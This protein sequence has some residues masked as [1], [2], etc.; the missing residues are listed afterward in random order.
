MKRMI[1]ESLLNQN[2]I[3]KYAKDFL[4]Y[5]E[6][7]YVK[8]MGLGELVRVNAT[9]IHE[10]TDLTFTAH[11]NA[12]IFIY[13]NLDWSI[14]DVIPEISDENPDYIFSVYSKYV[15]G[16]IEGNLKI[17]Q[18]GSTLYDDVSLLNK[19][20]LRLPSKVVSEQDFATGYMG[21]NID[22]IKLTSQDNSKH[23]IESNVEGV[24]KRYSVK[25]FFDYVN[26]IL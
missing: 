10:Q 19:G 24:V 26:G 18:P 5:E 17:T 9:E 16:E 3:I 6:P 11:M 15:L 21:N 8:F 2:S 23:Y 12:V 22:K 14:D 4:G 7:I 1:D 13:E 20:W 25:E